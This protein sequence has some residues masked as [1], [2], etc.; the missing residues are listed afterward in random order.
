VHAGRAAN[1]RFQDYTFPI[2]YQGPTPQLGSEPFPVP[3]VLH[4]MWR[5][6]EGRLGLLIAN[7]TSEPQGFRATLDP[8][9][10][11][12]PRHGYRIRE[13]VQGAPARELGTFGGTIEVRGE[14]S[15]VVLGGDLFLGRLAPRVLRVLV[16]EP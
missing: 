13:L 7:W 9:L 3:C 8:E 6:V 11:D 15:P 5:S 4:A 1:P 12:L 2:L 16:F 14:D 10:Y